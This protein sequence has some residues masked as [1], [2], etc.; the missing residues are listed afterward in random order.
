MKLWNLAQMVKFDNNCETWLKC[1]NL[2]EIVN[3]FEMVNC[4]QIVEFGLAWSGWLWIHNHKSINQVI[5]RVGIGQLKRTQYVGSIPKRVIIYADMAKFA[6]FC[7]EANVG[8]FT[9][10]NLYIFIHQVSHIC[11]LT[12]TIDGQILFER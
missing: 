10:T 5:P 3:T 1:W 12:I 2:V 8:N 11:G 6:P 4:G 9:C 7:G